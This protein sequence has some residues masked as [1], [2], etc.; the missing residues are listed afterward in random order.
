MP[1]HAQRLLASYLVKDE[2]QNQVLLD[3]YLKLTYISGVMYYLSSTINPLLY[4]LMSAK[5]RLA[6]KETFKCSLFKCK[7]LRGSSTNSNHRNPQSTKLKQTGHGISPTNSVKDAAGQPHHQ[8]QV[9]S[10]LIEPSSILADCS[11]CQQANQLD[12][13]STANANGTNNAIQIQFS[14]IKA[15]N[16]QPASYMNRLRVRLNSSLVSLFRTNDTQ[17]NQ[18]NC[19]CCCA[20]SGHIHHRQ[21]HQ[22]PPRSASAVN[23][24]KYF[25]LPFSR[26][27]SANERASALSSRENSIKINN[28]SAAAANLDKQTAAVA[29]AAVSSTTPLLLENNHSIAEPNNHSSGKL[30]LLASQTAAPSSPP[31]PPPQL[32]HQ[33]TTMLKFIKRGPEVSLGSGIALTRLS[34]REEDDDDE[35]PPKGTAAAEAAEGAPKEQQEKPVAKPIKRDVMEALIRGSE[36]AGGKLPP[37]ICNANS[38]AAVATNGRVYCDILL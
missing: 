9:G 17:L 5:F 32:P 4:Q 6:F 38:P 23:Y 22:Q 20:N 35:A 24:Y 16:G 14:D 2:N 13:V 19:C 7:L 10:Q 31:P 11:Y 27:N 12:C 21:Q 3:I 33:N 29:A 30:T 8:A 1:F 25:K 18:G 37:A 36:L 28:S 15:M 34:S 26:R